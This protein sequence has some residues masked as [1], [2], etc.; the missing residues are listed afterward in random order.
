MITL[1]RIRIRAAGFS[2]DEGWHE[3]TYYP[4][5][6]VRCSCGGGVRDIPETGEYDGGGCTH[7][8]ALYRGDITESHSVRHR[9]EDSAHVDR[10]A[11]EDRDQPWYVEIT[12]AG[13]DL[14]DWRWAMKK[15][16]SSCPPGMPK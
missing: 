1:V 16:V 11:W 13:H 3:I 14:F 4:S 12:P 7:I 5:R 2:A 8:V 9:T 10:A 15:L 6:A